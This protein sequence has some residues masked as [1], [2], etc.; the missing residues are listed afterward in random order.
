MVKIRGVGGAVTKKA[1]KAEVLNTF[2]ISVF[3]S[4]LGP[5]VDANT[6]PPSV[7]E[8]LVCELLKELDPY[9]SMGPKNIHT[10]VLRKL[11]DVVVRPLSIIFEKS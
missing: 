1:E 6:D 4:T 7:K 10:R 2:F 9:K 3:T 8:A 5:Q 11:A